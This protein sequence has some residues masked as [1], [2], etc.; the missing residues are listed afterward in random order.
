[1]RDGSLLWAGA[2]KV[3]GAGNSEGQDAPHECIVAPGGDGR[4]GS[5]V[6][7]GRNG[8]DGGRL[9]NDNRRGVPTPGAEVAER[10]E[11][12]EIDGVGTEEVALSRSQWEG[13]RGVLAVGETSMVRLSS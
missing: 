12:N 8:L 11:D 2:P 1:M 7:D 3:T 10:K 4:N 13:S 5:G 9:V 6:G